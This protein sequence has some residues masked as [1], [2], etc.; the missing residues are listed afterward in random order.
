[1]STDGF[2][3]K[4]AITCLAYML[5]AKL[6]SY[7]KGPLLGN[8]MVRT[9]P[10]FSMRSA[11]HSYRNRYACPIAQMLEAGFSMRST[12]RLLKVSVM[13][14]EGSRWSPGCEYVRPEVED[15]PSLEVATQQRDRG[16]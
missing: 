9:D 14:F 16:Y 4:A 10:A 3:K 12:L 8:S 1:M 13:K 6:W 7:K 5:K 2:R 15:R 11:P